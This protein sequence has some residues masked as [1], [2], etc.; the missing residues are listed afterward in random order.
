MGFKTI[1]ILAVMGVFHGAES[2][3]DEGKAK[4]KGW[5]A[6]LRAY[7]ESTTNITTIVAEL[8]KADEDYRKLGKRRLSPEE[9]AKLLEDAGFNR[10][11]L[12]ILKDY[13]DQTSR[14]ERIREQLYY[15][16]LQRSRDVAGFLETLLSRPTDPSAFKGALDN[17]CD[18]SGCLVQIG[19]DGKPWKIKRSDL[20]AS[21]SRISKCNTKPGH[22]ILLGL[23]RDSSCDSEV[24][25]LTSILR[26]LKTETETKLK[27]TIKFQEEF[28][29]TITP[30]RALGINMQDHILSLGITTT[31]QVLGLSALRIKSKDWAIDH[32][33]FLLDQESLKKRLA[34]N[35]ELITASETMIEDLAKKV[36]VAYGENLLGEFVN[37]QIT[38]ALSDFCQKGITQCSQPI[39]Q[40]AQNESER[41]KMIKDMSTFLKTA[42]VGSSASEE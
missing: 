2:W 26:E 15:E 36:T 38:R 11:K 7:S 17:L 21:L 23:D 40:D 42:P 20:E 14:D 27:A 41:G 37:L 5:D 24:E 33:L 8:T 16:E 10:K 12:A 25:K 1:L 32:E 31:D 19:K 35:L 34:G 22:W 18:P 13:L 39:P 9:R 29:K 28:K 30:I 4:L 6:V 3:G